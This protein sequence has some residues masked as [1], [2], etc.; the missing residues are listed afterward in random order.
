MMRNTST[1]RF[2]TVLGLSAIVGILGL[3]GVGLAAGT[4]RP[5]FGAGPVVKRLA[6]PDRY[7]TAVAASVE[8]WASSQYVVIATGES[9]P[10]ALVGAPLAH[11]HGAPL[12]LVPRGSL[13]ASVSAEITRLSATKAIILGGTGA[14]GTAVENSLRTMLQ[15]A[16]VERIAGSSRYDTARLIAMRL[17]DRYA[18]G[19]G[20]GG[21]VVVATGA[22]FPDAMAAAPF[23]AYKRYPILLTAAAAI[24]LETRN[25]LSSLGA[26]STIV[27]GGTGAVSA[28]AMEYL[29]ATGRHPERISGGSR[30]DTAA[31]IASYAA[32]NGCSFG[33]VVLATGV[34]FPDALVGG[35]L[36]ARSAGVTLLTAGA[37]LSVDPENQVLEHASEIAEIDILGGTGVV[38]SAAEDRAKAILA[39]SPPAWAPR[40]L[41]SKAG[42]YY[43][44][45]LA[46][47]LGADGTL[48]VLYQEGARVWYRRFD[49]K[50]NTVVSPVPVPVDPFQS[51]GVAESYPELAVAPDGQVT[52]F[53]SNPSSSPSRDGVFAL[54]FDA[55]GRPLRGPVR[56]GSR[57]V[58][59]LSATCDASGDIHLVGRGSFGPSGYAR[60]RPDLSPRLG[61]PGIGSSGRTRLPVVAARPSG[62]AEVVWYDARDL[63]PSPASRYQL[64]HSR[65]AWSGGG[66]LPPGGGSID[67]ARLTNLTGGFYE[68]DIAG[69]NFSGWSFPPGMSIGSNGSVHI[70]WIN[71]K[72]DIWYARLDAAG[73]P[74]I[75][76]TKVVDV[77]AFSSDMLPMVDTAARTDGGADIVYAYNDAIAGVRLAYLKVAPDGR[78]VG[79]G[80]RIPVLLARPWWFGLERNG[81]SLQLVYTETV[82]G[83]YQKVYYTDTLRDAAAYDTSRC[84]LVIDDAHSVNWR[85]PKEGQTV[86]MTVQVA[87]HGWIASPPSAAVFSYGGKSFATITVPPLAVDAVA[88]VTAAWTVPGTFT[89][90]PATITVSVDTSGVVTE[91]S[92]ANNSIE[93]PVPVRLRPKDVT[94]FF[95]AY[96]ETFDETHENGW[97]RVDRIRA[98]LTGTS[99]EAP[100]GS[101]SQTIDV[102]GSV[103]AGAFQHVPP[104]NYSMS[105]VVT[106]CASPYSPIA[107]TVS[108]VTTDPYTI[109][110]TPNWGYV[111][112]W[113]NT[114]GTLGGKVWDDNGTPGNTA[115]DSPVTLANVRV[116]E[117]GRVATTTAGGTFA[118]PKMAAGTYHLYVTADG[119]A[120]QRDVPVTVTVGGNSDVQLRMGHTTKAYVDV[121]AV[122]SYGTPVATATVAVHDASHAAQQTKTTDDDGWVSFEVPGGVPFHLNAQKT[123]YK[124]AESTA[125]SLVAGREYLIG[126]ELPVNTSMLTRSGSPWVNYNT[127]SEFFD[128]LGNKS[129]TSYRNFRMR[130]DVDYVTELG[131][132]RVLSVH[133]YAKGLAFLIE[134]L[135]V[136][137]EY[138]VAGIPIPIGDAEVEIQ[139]KDRSNVWIRHVKLIDTADGTV[140]FDSGDISD[141]VRTADDPAGIAG[142]HFDPDKYVNWSTVEMWTW[143]TVEKVD[144]VTGEWE[145]SPLG[146]RGSNSAV[147]VY[148]PSTKAQRVE[149]WLFDP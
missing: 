9:F 63:P 32:A 102:T 55:G 77:P 31:R 118:L 100:F 38:G 47:E 18:S 109:D 135:T 123:Y 84:D 99:T 45:Q 72:E 50:G 39:A 60:L 104:G 82:G 75:A 59:F 2:R 56:V 44:R 68:Q 33:T 30:Y 128:I 64:Y 136:P 108:R 21:R 89:A 111:Q 129:L 23:A 114:W 1:S 87:N 144:T 42:D 48:H 149:P 83:A 71:G 120:R 20:L 5:A 110:I 134:G 116:L 122:S 6:G 92:E 24:P 40:R 11:A 52:V 103:G 8:G 57:Y 121:S 15:S 106:G 4:V 41:V 67:Q 79:T 107:V 80:S 93:H 27:V 7:K 10:D 98:T 46:T 125:T 37:G 69:S 85:K 133:S 12:L 43:V 86:T 78:P 132:A 130:C 14:V 97:D 90:D 36:A 148:T 131:Q 25:A 139:T 76:A 81:S 22:T 26:T 28:G 73:Q 113:S 51:G 88:P 16:N 65:V 115:D 74:S 112:C 126:I 137:M 146:G 54:Q 29:A 119:F 96:D 140:K 95:G 53:W 101:Y 19:P 91:C 13:P 145:T 127:F 35:P 34:N 124:P 138:E 147:V 49:A 105:Y 3:L 94:V 58:R 141:P 117:N 61:W 70:G 143:V 17:R 66:L 62:I 142:V